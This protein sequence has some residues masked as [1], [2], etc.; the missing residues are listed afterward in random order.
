MSG[1]AETLSR[2]WTLKLSAFG[3]AV[4]LWAVVQAEPAEREIL[5]SVPVRVQVGDLGWTLDGDPDP[6]FVQV[7]FAGPAR[8]I[9]ELNRESAAVRIPLASVTSAD[10]LVQLRRDWVVIEGGASLVVQDIVPGS[11]RLRFEESRQVALPLS[12]R[13]RGTLPR[14]IA[15]AAPIGLTPPVVRVRGPVRVL[16]RLDSIPLMPLDLSAVSSSGMVEVAV[17]TAGLDG[18]TLTP[19]RAQLGVRVEPAAERLLAAVRV[20]V[21]GPAAEAL[22][23]EPV[24]VAVTVQGARARLDAA[25]LDSIR[26]EV[27]ADQ[28]QDVVPG[29]SRRVP[30]RIRGVPDLLRAEAATDSVTVRRPRAS[31]VGGAAPD[32]TAGG[33]PGGGS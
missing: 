25:M 24:T 22:Q 26:V 11:V 31:E 30:V 12:V 17:D 20:E 28:V 9:L 15:L 27:P 2:N 19:V 23:V 5:S 6:R 29:E 4:F 3:L 1:L 7:R 33:A 16:E 21:E 10:T 18:V 14:G 8:Q 32:S 13:T